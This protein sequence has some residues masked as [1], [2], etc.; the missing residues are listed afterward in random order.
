MINLSIFLLIAFFK[1]LNILLI[2]DNGKK[3]STL[4]KLNEY[5]YLLLL[6]LYAVSPCYFHSG[7]ELD[8]WL[9]TGLIQQKNI[10]KKIFIVVK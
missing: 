9:R 3:K 5:F 2:K 10:L 1:K 6:K 7:G 4:M 8:E